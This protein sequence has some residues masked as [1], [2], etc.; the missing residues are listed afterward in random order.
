MSV[1][2][3]TKIL[4]EMQR[5]VEI[6]A[7]IIIQKNGL[8]M[9]GLWYENLD[10]VTRALMVSEVDAGEVYRSPRLNGAGISRWPIL[11]KEAVRWHDYRWLSQQLA[12]QRL[13]VDRET[14][15]S[16]TGKLTWRAIDIQASAAILARGEFNRY[17]V[18]A[19]CVRA[20]EAGIPDLEICPGKNTLELLPDLSIAI[21]ER[22][23]QLELCC[24][25]RATELAPDAGVSIGAVL[26]LDALRRP[27]C[28]SRDCACIVPCGLL[29]ASLTTRLPQASG[30][31]RPAAHKNS[32]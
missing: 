19:L 4:F 24:G 26:L 29:D 11:L 8:G 32:L 3:P 15:T 31:L 5:L 16:R 1:S 6:M 30:E 27:D 13:V 20:M 21:R 18:R 14:Y 2:W 22:V 28:A 12:A 25:R 9:S 7:L 10:G 23:Q 17:Y